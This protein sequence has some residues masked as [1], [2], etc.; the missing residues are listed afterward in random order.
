MGAGQVQAISGRRGEVCRQLFL[1]DECLAEL[2]FRILALA[3]LVQEGAQGE[4]GSSQILAV[5]HSAWRFVGRLSSQGQSLAEVR[6]GSFLMSFGENGGQI[7]MSA[8]ELGSKFGDGGK[9]ARQ[10]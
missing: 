7:V 8:S 4:M 5:L 6:L 3:D 10:L 9:F 1:Q 2:N